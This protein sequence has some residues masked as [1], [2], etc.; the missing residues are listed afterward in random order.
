MA[1]MV[2]EV[3]N[4]IKKINGSAKIVVWAHNSHVGNALATE[5]SES[6]ELSLGQLVLYR[7]W[8]DCYLVGFT[9]YNGT[10][11]AASQW[12]AKVEKKTLNPAIDGSYEELFHNTDIKTFL[13]DFNDLPSDLEAFKQNH[14]ERSVGVVYTP[15]SERVS[16]Y[17]NARMADQFHA[18]IHID[19]TSA[20]E[21]LF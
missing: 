11:A 9:T 12:G 1:D 10:V 17:F 15:E 19:S 8:G 7:H 16:H 3:S 13:L 2:E 20:V 6:E 14:L 5:F 18:V 4:H 21:P